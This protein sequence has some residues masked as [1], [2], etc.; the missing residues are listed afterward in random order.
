MACSAKAKAALCCAVIGVFIV[1]ITVLS[2]VVARH[3]DPITITGANA[4][5]KQISDVRN[6]LIQLDNR[7]NISGLSL[8][9]IV[10]LIMLLL[11]AR[12]GHHVLVKRPSK[13]LKRVVNAQREDRIIKIEGLL[14]AKGYMT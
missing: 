1:V 11:S 10:I 3:Q 9:C 7:V 4:H 12:A 2:I 6:S 5:V 8:G 14:K 13:A